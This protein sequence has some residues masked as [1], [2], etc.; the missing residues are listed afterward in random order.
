MFFLHDPF[1]DMHM[2][3][4]IYINTQDLQLSVCSDIEQYS[5]SWLEHFKIDIFSNNWMK[6]SRIAVWPCAEN[7]FLSMA[8]ITL[9]FKYV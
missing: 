8:L 7:S 6:P 5:I 3:Q 2:P 1:W 9:T 4:T